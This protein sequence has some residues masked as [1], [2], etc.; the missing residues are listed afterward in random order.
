ME[1]N[2]EKFMR[3]VMFEFNDI[4]IR[5]QVVNAIEPFCR[6]I[7]AKRGLIDYKIVCDESNNT[8][9]VIENNTLVCDVYLKMAHVIQFIELNFIITKTSVSFGEA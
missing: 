1:F 9:S 2:L 8:P 3:Q 7:K 6:N 5:G 4:I